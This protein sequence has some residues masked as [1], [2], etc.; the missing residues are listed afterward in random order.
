MMNRHFINIKVDREQRPDLDSIYMAATVAMTGQG[1]WPMSV[2]LTPDLRPFY[3]G[4]YFPP[5]PRYN[6]PSFRDLLT[7]IVRA[8]ANERAEVF[9]VAANVSEHLQRQNAKRQRH[10]PQPG[11]AR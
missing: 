1:G 7:G 11:P 6:M 4:T 5:T 10:Q 3:A 8:W 9:K 2:F